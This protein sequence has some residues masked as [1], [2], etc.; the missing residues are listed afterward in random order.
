MHPYEDIR[1]TIL[2]RINNQTWPAGSTLPHEEQLA[3][4]FDVARGTIRR[5]LSSLVEAGLIERRRK[6]GTRVVDRRSHMSTLNI[7]IIRHEIESSG[8]QYGYKLLSSDIHSPEKDETGFFKTASLKHV[9]ALHLKDGRPFQLEDRLI[10]LTAIPKARDESFK[11][12]SPNEWLVAQ[13]PYSSIR[14]Y[15]RAELA[16]A[17]DVTHLKITTG[18]PVF[19]VERQTTLKTVPLTRVRLSHDAAQYQVVTETADVT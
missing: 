4:E 6:A 15:L 11:T 12:I 9:L 14:T 7:P 8:A 10:N 17:L 18:R 1:A 13:V 19:I 3:K 16:S 2:E 5:A